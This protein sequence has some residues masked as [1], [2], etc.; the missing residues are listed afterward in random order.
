VN[1]FTATT[2]PCFNSRI[3]LSPPG[4]R[5]R[6]SPGT[7]PAHGH[8]LPPLSSRGTQESARSAILPAIN[9]STMQGSSSQ[10]SQHASSSSNPA[11]GADHRSGPSPLPPSH[12]KDI[13]AI[14]QELQ[15]VL[16]DQGLPYWTALGDYLAYRLRHDEFLGMV[17]KW[18]G[19][20]GASTS[21]SCDGATIA[22][23]QLGYTIS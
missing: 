10:A 20:N 12:R 17:K 21:Y 11:G 16:G 23:K 19:R 6:L 2:A 8:R 14:K 1:W 7:I 5:L 18:L 22:D 9:M 13:N 15:D 4:D 3:H